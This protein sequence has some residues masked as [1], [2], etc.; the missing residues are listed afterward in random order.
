MPVSKTGALGREVKM[1]MK[2]LDVDALREF[3]LN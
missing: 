2:T 3:S 1:P